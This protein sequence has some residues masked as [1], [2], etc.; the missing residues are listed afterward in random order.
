MQETASLPTGKN[1]YS[2]LT[3]LAPRA[4]ASSN[5]NP[6][7][8]AY[9]GID[10]TPHSAAIAAVENPAAQHQEIRMLRHGRG[11]LHSRGR[12]RSRSRRVLGTRR[13]R[14]EEHATKPPITRCSRG[15]LTCRSIEAVHHRVLRGLAQSEPFRAAATPR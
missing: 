7:A 10:T 4:H 11:S 8:G 9:T 2:S 6:A 14:R 12:G 3:P 13:H 1:G 15:T 5:A